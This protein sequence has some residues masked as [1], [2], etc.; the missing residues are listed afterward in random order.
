MLK[1]S[2]SGVFAPPPIFL[3]LPITSPISNQNNLELKG[4]EKKIQMYYIYFVLLKKSTYIYHL[5][6]HLFFFEKALQELD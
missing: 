2:L 3:L 4:E 6:K 5:N 1:I